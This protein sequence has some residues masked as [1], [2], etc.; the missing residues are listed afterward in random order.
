MKF[1]EI[2]RALVRPYLEIILGSSMVGLAIYLTIKHADIE[3]AKY[4]V[5]AV[6]T[7]GISLF[8]YYFGERAGK[9]KEDK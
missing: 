4:I 7:A 2:L 6:V 9:K 1:I 3:L 5:T 8:G